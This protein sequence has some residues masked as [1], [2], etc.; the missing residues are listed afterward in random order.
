M[1]I[2]ITQE[3][4]VKKPKSSPATPEE[5]GV[6]K[7]KSETMTKQ[8]NYSDVKEDL[9]LKALAVFFLIGVITTLVFSLV[10]FNL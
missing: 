7:P 2:I 1:M 8:S 9:S 3:K 10:L 6:K 5:M 4:P